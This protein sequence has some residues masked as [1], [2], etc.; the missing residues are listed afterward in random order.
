MDSKYRV[1]CDRDCDGV[2]VYLYKTCT[3][4]FSSGNFTLHKRYIRVEMHI[5][6]LKQLVYNLTLV[7]YRFV[8]LEGE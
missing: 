6:K 5:E 2:H 1:T 4:S 7:H 8:Q 3:A